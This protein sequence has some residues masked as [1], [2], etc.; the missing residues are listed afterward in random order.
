M[1]NSKSHEWTTLQPARS[2]NPYEAFRTH[3]CGSDSLRSI[4][5]LSD[6]RVYRD[7]QHYFRVADTSIRM[8]KRWVIRFKGL[9][10]SFSPPR[11]SHR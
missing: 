6:E 3:V 5:K 8:A 11:P 2:A 9:L 7:F 1:L 4:T 10:S